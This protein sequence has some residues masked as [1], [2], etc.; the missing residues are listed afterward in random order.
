M[1]DP[2]MTRVPTRSGGTLPEKHSRSDGSAW[3]RLQFMGAAQRRRCAIAFVGV[4][5]TL[6]ST[7]A[8]GKVPMPRFSSREQLD[9]RAPHPALSPEYGSTAL[10]AGGEARN[11]HSLLQPRPV[12]RPVREE[13]PRTGLPTRRLPRHG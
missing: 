8:M 1:G 9:V 10:T 12:H 3:L 4:P 7:R 6:A 2:P 5:P 13:R 11:R